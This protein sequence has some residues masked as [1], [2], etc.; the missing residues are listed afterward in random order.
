M[1]GLTL[2]A[3]LVAALEHYRT[4]HRARQPF[5]GCRTS[6]HYS[7]SVPKEMTNMLHNKSRKK[8][9]YD[10]DINMQNRDVCAKLVCGAVFRTSVGKNQHLDKHADNKDITKETYG[11]Y[12]VY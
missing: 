10:Y 12:E 8:F 11:D 2:K 5:Q 6:V 7:S 9:Y 4:E 1:E 3:S